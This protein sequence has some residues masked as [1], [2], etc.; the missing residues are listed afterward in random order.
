MQS[1]NKER[2]TKAQLIRRAIAAVTAV[3][4]AI[5]TMPAAV[6]IALESLVMVLDHTLVIDKVYR[7]D[8]FQVQGYS[9]D[10]VSIYNGKTGAL[11]KT[12]EDYAYVGL[13]NNGRALVNKG[14]TRRDEYGNVT[15][16]KWGF[17]DKTGS[18][19]LPCRY[20]WADDFSE[21]VA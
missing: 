2:V 20:D 17:I 15:G 1:I 12:F 4:I 18:E 13:F 8:G 19:V 7:I 6:G 5:T 3:V 21:E 11:V 14:G 9:G 16:G 10:K